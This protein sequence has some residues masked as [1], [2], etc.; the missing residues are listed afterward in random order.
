MSLPLI[1]IILTLFNNENSIIET[2]KS[3]LDQTYPNIEI[4]ITDN[5]S[6]DNT[7][8]VLEKY[9]KRNSNIRLLFEDAIPTVQAQKSTLIR[10]KGKYITFLESGKLL[11]KNYIEYAISKLEESDAQIISTEYFSIP[12]YT[13]YHSNN[14]SKKSP[15]EKIKIISNTEYLKN[16]YLKSEH[17]Y[18]SCITLWNKIINKDWLLSTTYLKETSELVTSYDIIKQPSTILTTNQILICDVKYDEYYE[19]I[20]FNYENMDKIE[21][22][23]QLLIQAKKENNSKAMYNTSIRLL[24]Y[25]LFVRKQLSYSDLEILNPD[26]LRNK[27]NLKFH[28]IYK[29]LSTKYPDTKIEYE[30]YKKEYNKLLNFEKKHFKTNLLF[31]ERQQE[32][33]LPIFLQKK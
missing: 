10:A 23:E 12:F 9:I 19:N 16:L 28:S 31:T 18:Q 6:F 22:L 3:I 5:G 8:D 26:E 24:K 27:V 32:E 15:Q 20:C 7:V 21:F 13:F 14:I 30:Q 2:L 1:T 33:P 25:L 4:L 29:F 17:N 11:S